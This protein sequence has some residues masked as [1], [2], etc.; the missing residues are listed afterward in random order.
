[1]L[2]QGYEHRELAPGLGGAKWFDG[3]ASAGWLHR[4]KIGAQSEGTG[5]A[6]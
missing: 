6:G 1:M 4:L 3:V 2:V 5:W